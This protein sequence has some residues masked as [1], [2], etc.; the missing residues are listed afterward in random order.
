VFEDLDESS[1]LDRPDIRLLL[2]RLPAYAKKVIL[3][4]CFLHDSG[5]LRRGFGFGCGDRKR[6][7][8]VLEFWWSIVAPDLDLLDWG[9]TVRRLDWERLHRD[10]FELIAGRRDIVHEMLDIGRV[11]VD[12]TAGSTQNIG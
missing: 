9:G 4:E 1:F 7:F 12:P 6:E 5:V 11:I 8:V 10:P 2:V 3:P